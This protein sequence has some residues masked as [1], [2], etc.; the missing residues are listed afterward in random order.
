MGLLF[1]TEENAV[2]VV[3]A[4]TAA[5]KTVGMGGC[6]YWEWVGGVG[7]CIIEVPP[8]HRTSLKRGTKKSI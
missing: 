8:V 3:V 1:S 6:F 5:L 2:F 4:A 7:R